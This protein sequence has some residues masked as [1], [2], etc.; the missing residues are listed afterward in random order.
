MT[1]L[2]LLLIPLAAAGLIAVTRR[3][4]GVE[5]MHVIAAMAALSAGAAI[6]VE[7]W[8]GKVLTAAGDLFRADAL[9]ALMVALIT[10]LGA[11]ASL[12]AVGYIRAE[13]EDAQL[14]RV[15]LFFTLFHL[16]IF[17]MLVA[18]TTDN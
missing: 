7:V 15:R 18:V 8:N 10:F 14:P 5:L 6:A 13:L 2:S 16:F 1:L 4:V 3:R 17:T 11:I 12:Y 9:S